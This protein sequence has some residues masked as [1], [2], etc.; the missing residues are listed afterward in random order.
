M[1]S[2]LLTI[3]LLYNSVKSLSVLMVDF[4]LFW[5]QTKLATLT[6]IN[7]LKFIPYSTYQT[8][9]K[10]GGTLTCVQRKTLEV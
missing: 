10:D 6:E 8:T 3:L 7:I 4:P 2:L 1:I 9:R 5:E